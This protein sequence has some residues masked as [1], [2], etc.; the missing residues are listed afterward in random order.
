MRPLALITNDDSI[1]ASG[2]KRLID[3]ALDEGCDVIAVAPVTPQSGMSSAISVDKPLRISQRPDYREARMY[4]VSGTPVDCIKLALSE[5]CP[6]KPDFVFSGI[7]HGSNSG[8]AITYSGTMGA[9]LEGCTNKIVSVGF[10]LCD[11]SLKA[12]FSLSMPFIRQIMAR[13]MKDGLPDYVA[14]N[15]N[16]PAKVV[17]LG[18]KVCRAARG[19]WSEEYAR[20]TDP[21]GKPFYWLTGRFVNDDKDATDTDEYWLANNYISLVPVTPDQSIPLNFEI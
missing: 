6:R 19:H 10:S 5:I 1:A 8:N 12:D 20:Y 15:V 16:I 2:L 18:V 3:C 13:V 7:N 4:T 14:L 21:M 9:V 17:P 11:H